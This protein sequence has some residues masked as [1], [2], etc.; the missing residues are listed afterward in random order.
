MRTAAST[1]FNKKKGY[2]QHMIDNHRIHSKKELM[3]FLRDG[4]K[5][6]KKVDHVYQEHDHMIDPRKRCD[7][8]DRHLLYPFERDIP[9]P[10]PMVVK[11]A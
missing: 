2:A 8:H 5:Y 7:R 6:I 1:C 10:T 9:Q 3:Y 11:T 4:N